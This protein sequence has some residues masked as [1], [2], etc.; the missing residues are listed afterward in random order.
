[1]QYEQSNRDRRK[2]HF[3]SLLMIG[4]SF[5]MAAALASCDSQKNQQSKAEKTVTVS[6]PRVATVTSYLYQTGTAK[7]LDSVDIVARVAGTLTS[8][9]Y[10]DGTEVKAGQRL[11][12]IEPDQ[13]EAQ[14]N[15]AQATV[16]Q[17]QVTLDNAQRQL[18]RQ[19]QLARTSV[20]TES[21]VDNAVASRDTAKAQL[22][23][24]KAS[25]RQAQINLGYT[26][27]TAPFDGFVTEHEADVGALVGSGGTTKLATIVKL[28]PIHVSFSISDTDMLRLRSKARE[29]GLTPKDLVKVRVDAATQLDVGFPHQ[30]RLDYVAPQ[31]A[32]DTGTLSVRA[33]FDNSDRALLPGLFVRLRIPVDTVKDGL[34]VSPASIGTDQQ[35][36][37]VMVVNASGMVER[38]SVNLLERSGDLQQVEGSLSASDWVLRNALAGVRAGDTVVAQQAPLPAEPADIEKQNAPAATGN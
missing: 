35:G 18:D 36:R 3:T 4:L 17:A 30:G 22:D 34:L 2:G 29:R 26:S 7:A 5:L 33:A 16:E 20:T 13:Y 24:A 8:I 10:K 14:L 32:S 25:L 6:Q 31:T 21:N 37:F 38:R 12:L 28:D 27:I 15:Q 1:M 23:A 11:F 9:D 19:G